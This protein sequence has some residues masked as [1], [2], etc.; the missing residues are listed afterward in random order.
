MRRPARSALAFLGGFSLVSLLGCSDFG[1]PPEPSTPPDVQ[2]PVVQLVRPNGGE[3]WESGTSQSVA[4]QVTDPDTPVGSLRIALDLSRDGGSS[5]EPIASDLPAT[6]SYSWTVPT[7]LT[8]Q[9]RIRITA[10]DGQRSSSD[11]S[12]AQFSIIRVPTGGEAIVSVGTGAGTRGSS[13]TVPLALSNS[14]D[15]Q[16]VELEL[17]YDPGLVAFAGAAT[18]LR[19]AELSLEAVATDGVISIHLGDDP[20]DDLLAAGTGEI[21]L[22]SFELV[23]VG[24]SDLSVVAIRIANAAGDSVSVETSDGGVTVQPEGPPA[25]IAEL[26]PERTVVGDTVRVLGVGFG[27]EQG[28]GTVALESDGSSSLATVLQWSDAEVRALVPDLEGANRLRLTTNGGSPATADFAVAPKL[29]SL[30]NDLLAN[31]KSLQRYGCVSCHFCPGGSGDFCVNTR[32][33]MLHG[34]NNSRGTAIIPRK[35]ALSVMIR[36][37]GPNPPFGDRMPQGCEQVPN[38]IT[39]ADLLEIRDWIDQGARDN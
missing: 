24:Q 39:A 35:S 19:A 14:A 1:D 34:G 16:T 18:T 22:L 5:F 27:A 3:E 13:Q 12:D 25:E 20:P 10:S 11:L 37:M 21:L 30:R 6:S 8:T 4:W 31:G 23:A 36:K 33:Q 7:G 2:P 29:V 26:L 38:C 9:A 15:I 17:S 32:E 28:S